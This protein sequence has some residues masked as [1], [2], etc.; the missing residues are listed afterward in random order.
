MDWD[1]HITELWALELEALAADM[2]D[3]VPA[4]ERGLAMCTQ[5]VVLAALVAMLHRSFRLVVME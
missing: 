2:V 4:G 1:F 5:W 3:G